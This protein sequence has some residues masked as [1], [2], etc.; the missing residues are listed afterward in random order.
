MK[1]AKKVLV[2]IFV[3]CQRWKATSCSSSVQT[4]IEIPTG[5]CV[6]LE[7]FLPEVSGDD[8]TVR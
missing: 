4:D 8:V 1:K 5:A 7:L 2:N 3:F 6:F